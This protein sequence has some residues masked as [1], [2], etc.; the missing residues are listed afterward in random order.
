MINNTRLQ[1]SILKYFKAL[2]MTTGR[3][4][5]KKAAVNDG[6]NM[7]RFVQLTGFSEHQW[8]SWFGDG[9]EQHSP[10]VEQFKS[11][12]DSFGWSALYIFHGL[13]PH[14]L[15]DL[16][17]I[18]KEGA[19]ILEHREGALKHLEISLY[20]Q[21]ALKGWKPG[22]RDRASVFGWKILRPGSKRCTAALMRLR[23]NNS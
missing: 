5:A 9:K 20:N 19:E 4:R 14:K 16:M 3:M 7:K 22:W 10:S 2:L 11:L 15:T 12:I 6:I 17:V 21:E 18:L 8:Y 23:N 1:S 13:C